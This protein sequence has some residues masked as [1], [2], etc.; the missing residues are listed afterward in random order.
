M[1]SDP[2]NMQLLILL[3]S[4]IAI[5][6]SFLEPRK[7]NDSL[8]ISDIVMKEVSDFNSPDVKRT[9]VLSIWN[10][11]SVLSKVLSQTRKTSNKLA[12]VSTLFQQKYE[13]YI[14]DKYSKFSK[15]QIRRML[16]RFGWSFLNLPKG[17]NKYIAAK[18]YILLKSLLIG[19]LFHIYFIYFIFNYLCAWSSI[20]VNSD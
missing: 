13:N 19:F 12:G 3:A 4:T 14:K 5:C 6:S 17:S 1:V 9:K 16:F 10:D 15:E 7:S 18:W 8:L 20:Y 2:T 11:L